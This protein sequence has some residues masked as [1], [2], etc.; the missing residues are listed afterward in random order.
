MK[1]IYTSK[2]LEMKDGAKIKCVVVL[3]IAILHPNSGVH[4]R[5]MDVT[6][7]KNRLDLGSQFFTVDPADVSLLFSRLFAAYGVGVFSFR[8]DLNLT[9]TP[10]NKTLAGM[11]PGRRAILSWL[12]F[13]N[14]QKKKTALLHFTHNGRRLMGDALVVE[15]V[16]ISRV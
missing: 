6:L 5:C 3:K 13:P 15:T 16:R 10:T 7:L 1:Y 12:L 14:L 2:Q 11:D 8:H 9:L 4:Y